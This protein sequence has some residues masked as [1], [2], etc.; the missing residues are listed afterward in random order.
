MARN[1]QIWTRDGELLLDG[2]TAA[3]ADIRRAADR[4]LAGGVFLY[5]FQFPPMRV[6][7][8]D[9]YWQRPLCAC[10][11]PDRAEVRLIDADLNGYITAYDMG[12]PNC[13]QRPVEL[14]PRVL[15]RTVYLDLLHRIDRTHDRFRYQTTLNALNV[16]DTADL[17]RGRRLPRSFAEEMLRVA[18]D[19]EPYDEWLELVTDRCTTPDGREAARRDTA[20]ARRAEA[21]AAAARAHLSLDRDPCPTRKRTG[22]TSRPSRPANS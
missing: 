6:G 12:E 17:W 18:Q 16:L 8:H 10:S 1:C 13:I 21:P 11:V 22:D 2:P 14:Y 4:I 5:R 7:R 19:K 20:R 9:V 15:R 3:R